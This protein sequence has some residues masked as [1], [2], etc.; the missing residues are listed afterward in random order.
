MQETAVTVEGNV[1]IRPGF[2]NNS[3]DIQKIQN[4]LSVAFNIPSPSSSFWISLPAKKNEE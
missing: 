1:Q 2:K 3:A 4:K